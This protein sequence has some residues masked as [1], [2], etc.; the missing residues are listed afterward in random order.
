MRG[1]RIVGQGEPNW[2][3]RENARRI[4]SFEERTCA[5][6]RRF[7]IRISIKSQRLMSYA[8]TTDEIS[9][10]W[11]RQFKTVEKGLI[12]ERLVWPWTLKPL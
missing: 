11:N 10:R 8:W 4:N 3:R 2:S 5:R 1:N 9:S 6:N 7:E 12:F